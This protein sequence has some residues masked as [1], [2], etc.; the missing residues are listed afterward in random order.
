MPPAQVVA[1]GQAVLV[2]VVVGVVVVG[3]EVQGVPLEPLEWAQVVVA[4][5]VALE[6]GG[7]A[8]VVARGVARGESPVV[9]VVAVVT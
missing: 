8:R 3:F 4:V 7:V 6:G 2:Q 5:V 1:P 9:G